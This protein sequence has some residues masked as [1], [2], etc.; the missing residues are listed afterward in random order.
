M[1]AN[2]KYKKLFEPSYIGPVKTRNRII[3]TGASMLYWHEKETRM[4]Q[5]TL[6]FYEA[7]ARGGA[8]LLIVESPIL[9]YPLGGRWRERYR[10]DNDRYIKGMSELVSVIHKHGCPTFMQMCHD[11]PWQS[12]LFPNNPATFSGKPIGASPV[13]LDQPGDFHR[14]VPRQLKKSEIESL[15]DKI[16]AVAVRA[17]K[18]G[19]DGVDINAGSS[20][21]YHN[22]LSPFWNRRKDAYGGTQEKRARFLVDT[23]REIKKRTGKNFPVCICMN[24]I[25]VGQA[26]G[27]SNSDCLTHEYALE[28]ALLAQEAGADAIQVRSNW[29]GYHVGGFLPEQLYFPEFPVPVNTAPKEY[30]T[31]ERGKGANVIMAASFK[32]KL[33]VPVIAVGG[34]DAD[35]GEKILRSGKADFIAMHRPLMADPGYPNKIASGKSAEIAPCTRCG[36]CLDQSIAM[37][38]RCRINAAMGTKQYTV[39]KAGKKKKVIVIGGGPAGMEAARVA[40]LRGHNVTL[41]E[42]EHKLG[43]LLSVAALVKGLDI[44]DL[45]SIVRY[46]KAQFKALGVKAR[47]GKEVSPPVIKKLKP[48]ALILAGGGT[49]AIP[50]VLGINNANVITGPALHSRLK[51][52]LRFISTGILRWLTNFYLP[53]GEKVVII[54]SGMHGFE[55]AEF[56]IKRNRHVTIVDT[57]KEPGEGMLDYR[58]GLSLSWFEKKSVN[59]ITKLKKIEVADNGV[60]ITTDKGKTEI[61]EAD[62]IVPANPS[63]PNSE[64]QK[65]FED[66]I[67][68]VYAIGDCKEP[69]MIVDAIAAGWQT[70]NKI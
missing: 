69:A 40:A 64:M 41:Y 33:S 4:N 63:G 49:L 9:D 17:R 16:A 34:I 43:G 27:V 57:A 70:A 37:H 22:F 68:E 62:T 2:S 31:S 52:F 60:K 10:M 12:P 14:D 61:I 42:K 50:E 55:L 56:F 38:R 47:L 58:L 5:D 8:G 19:F 46:F 24:G 30:N 18:A 32:K 7:V 28:T 29:L 13:N 48:D 66:V 36:T 23:I 45:P 54:G 21:L 25:E 53:V 26:I 65:S 1:K 51:F 6:A 59:I 3:K 20:H 35:L 67:P 11:G 44:E 15:V 39:E